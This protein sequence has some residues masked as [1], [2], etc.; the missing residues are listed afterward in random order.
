MSKSLRA[1]AEAVVETYGEFCRGCE[2]IN[3]MGVKVIQLEAALSEPD[4]MA[5]ACQIIRDGMKFGGLA[6]VTYI[7]A[8][9]FLK[10]MEGT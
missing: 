2:T 1:A 8:R 7:R 10:R 3:D 5:E 4:P 6:G 9:E